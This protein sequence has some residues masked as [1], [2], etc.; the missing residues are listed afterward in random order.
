MTPSSVLAFLRTPGIVRRMLVLLAVGFVGLLVVGGASVWSLLRTQ[1][2]DRWVEH[3]QTVIYRTEGLFRLAVELMRI[4]SP[5]ATY[6]PF[7]QVF[8]RNS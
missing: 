2:Y 5:R 3:T 4:Q 1:D 8:H 7:Y 6:A